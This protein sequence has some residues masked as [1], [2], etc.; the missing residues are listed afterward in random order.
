M[1][2]THNKSW[3]I[4]DEVMNA[5]ACNL[6]TTACEGGINYWA[7]CENY[8][9]GDPSIGHSHAQA[10]GSTD[11]QPGDTQ[12]ATVTIH[13]DVD[14]DMEPDFQP[15]YVD[16]AKMIEAITKLMTTE[17]TFYT[18]GYSRTFKERL[19]SVFDEVSRGVDFDKADFDFDAG[20]A[21][22]MMQIAVL[23][24]TVYG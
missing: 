11:W 2:L 24:K 20:D 13:S 21:D 4:P 8:R 10:N 16:A 3:D 22:C 23:G 12:Y 15:V 7:A 14:P 1:Q 18:M 19:A 6:I 5:L 17:I 9:W